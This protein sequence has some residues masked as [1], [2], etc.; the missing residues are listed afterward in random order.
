M[1]H[2]FIL[3]VT[4]CTPA[5]NN[6]AYFEAHLVAAEVLPKPSK[7]NANKNV[8]KTHWNKNEHIQNAEY[9]CEFVPIDASVYMKRSENANTMAMKHSEFRYRFTI[10]N[11]LLIAFVSCILI[12]ESNQLQ[13]TI[14]MKWFFP[15]RLFTFG[16]CY[17]SV[18]IMRSQLFAKQNERQFQWCLFIWI[19]FI[20]CRKHFPL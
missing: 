9:L 17:C 3:Y 4:H 7:K 5:R 12:G 11:F 16:F 2:L 19:D 8:K 6:Y 13:L 1:L 10:L 15:F 14:W 20:K 18:M